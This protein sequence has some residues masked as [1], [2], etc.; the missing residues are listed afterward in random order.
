MKVSVE[1]EEINK[2]NHRWWHFP[3]VSWIPMNNSNLL[4][5]K[6]N[7]MTKYCVKV[8]CGWEIKTTK[9]IKYEL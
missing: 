6:K 3:W 7:S 9:R 2:E 4:D 5:R 8:G 1:V